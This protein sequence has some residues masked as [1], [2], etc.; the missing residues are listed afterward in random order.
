M[1]ASP[2]AQKVAEFNNR[3]Y[4]GGILSIAEPR[5]QIVRRLIGYESRKIICDIG[6]SDGLLGELL[7]KDG[8]QVY[9]ID[10]SAGALELAQSRG[11]TTFQL[12]LETDRLPFDDSSLD[13]VTLVE[14][15][16]QTYDTGRVLEE[17][18]RILKVGGQLVVSVPNVVSLGRRISHL[19]GRTP[20]FYQSLE[21]KG[22]TGAFRYFTKRSLFRLL[23]EHGFRPIRITSDFINIGTYGNLRSPMLAKIFPTLGSSLIVSAI[24]KR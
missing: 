1:M 18:R 7:L 23:E 21:D 11:L 5:Q 19:F 12:N 2:F 22:A 6:C 8:H 24:K 14:V 15:L 3:R 20:F 9:G 16:D 10:V 4:P 13:V 17:I